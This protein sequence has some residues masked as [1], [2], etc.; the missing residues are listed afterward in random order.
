MIRKARV[1][2]VQVI[3]SLINYHADEGQML[4]RTLNELYEHLR[5]F[6]LFEE[7]GVIGVRTRRVGQ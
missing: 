5:D 1:P 3:Q 7:K 2:D 4:P 6:S